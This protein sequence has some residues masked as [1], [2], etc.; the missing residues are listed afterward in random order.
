[1]TQLP[2]LDKNYLTSQG[3]VLDKICWLFYGITDGTVKIVLERNPILNEYPS[4]LPAGIL[5]ILPI[6]K[7][8]P[9]RQPLWDY[10]Q[11]TEAQFTLADNQD[12]EQE[13]R[14]ELKK[15]Q[16]GADGNIY[17]SAKIDRLYSPMASVAPILVGP[18]VPLSFKTEPLPTIPT[19]DADTYVG[20]YYRGPNNTFRVGYITKDQLLAGAGIEDVLVSGL[21]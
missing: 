19:K 2:K 13:I 10:I 16:S 8:E 14:N 1:M 4:V 15:Y 5:L 21:P 17:I 11:P 7:Y 12:A 20:I 18:Q 9:T 3:D 6:I